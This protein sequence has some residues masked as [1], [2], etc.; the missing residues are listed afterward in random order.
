MAPA[1]L[2]PNPSTP[3]K[4]VHL[5]GGI[6]C[7]FF[8]FLVSSPWVVLALSLPLTALFVAGAKLGFL[9]SLHGV[10]RKSRG[11]EYYPPRGLPRLPHDSG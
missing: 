4:L 6:A 8:P 1:G 3:A 2:P 10:G 7:L 11:A 9:Q 5:G